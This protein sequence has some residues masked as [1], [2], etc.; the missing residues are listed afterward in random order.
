MAA[1]APA[2]DRAD[3]L[4]RYNGMQDCR[5]AHLLFGGQKSCRIGC[6]GFGSC[7]RAC[8]FGAIEMG[9]HGLPIFKPEKCVACGLC[10]IACPVKAMSGI[11]I[12]KDIDI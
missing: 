12:D 1:G 6:L 5:A 7:V 3:E 10:K 11:A 9:K 8:R 4:Y 2:G